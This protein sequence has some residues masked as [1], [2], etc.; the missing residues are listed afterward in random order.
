MDIAVLT[1]V[2]IAGWARAIVGYFELRA[3]L[4]SVALYALWL[5]RMP[6]VGHI[7]EP[8]ELSLAR[9]LA[10]TQPVPL[11]ILKTFMKEEPTKPLPG[12]IT[13]RLTTLIDP[14][15]GEP[16]P[17]YPRFKLDGEDE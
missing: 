1:G 17:G 6:R 14:K 11:S 5:N 12:K 13:R 15:T 8:P 3:A 16:V 9:T 4:C 2:A 7:I 10:K